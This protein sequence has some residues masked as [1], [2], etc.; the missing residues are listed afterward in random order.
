MLKQYQQSKKKGGADL[1]KRPGYY[2]YGVPQNTANM[3][4]VGSIYSIAAA[5]QMEFSEFVKNTIKELSKHKSYFNILMH[6]ELPLYFQDVDHLMNAI[7]TYILDKNITIPFTKFTHWNDLFIDIARIIYG[8]T[9][10]ILEDLSIITTGTSIKAS[11]FNEEINIIL[12]DKI[13]YVDDIIPE[14]QMDGERRSYILIVKRSQKTKSPFRE[15]VKTYYP[16]FIFIPQIFFKTNDI[17]QRIYTESDEIIK[18]IRNILKNSLAKDVRVTDQPLDL[19]V[20]VKFIKRT[21]HYK[22]HQ[23]FINHKNMCYAALLVKAKEYVYVPLHFSYYK[24]I[25]PMVFASPDNRQKAPVFNPF[26]R[27]AWKI[28]YSALESFIADFNKYV[29]DVSEAQGMIRFGIPTTASREDRIIPTYSLI[30]VDKFLMF[31]PF[32]GNISGHA[33]GILSDNRQFYFEDVNEKQ[34]DK[35]FAMFKKHM[36]EYD[37][38]IKEMR[39]EIF[40]FLYYDPDVIN[41]TIIAGSLQPEVP[42][43]L[44]SRNIN[45]ALYSKYLYQLFV[46]QFISYFDKETNTEIRKKLIQL[47]RKINF[48]KT[49]A[50]AK[51]QTEMRDFIPETSDRDVIMKIV[52][53]Y[54]YGKFDKDATIEDLEQNRYQFDRT[55][56][57]K[58]SRLNRELSR[59]EWDAIDPEKGTDVHKKIKKQIHALVGSVVQKII[60]P[61][62]P[63]NDDSAFEILISCLDSGKDAKK[64]CVNKKLVMPADKIKDYTDILVDDLLDPLKNIYLMSSI[65]VE[66]ILDNFRFHKTPGED[67]YI[68]F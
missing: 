25:D 64:Y 6:G 1:A 11:A 22:I 21:K 3:S 56:L 4:N 14:I 29:L 5:M 44:S 19:H 10:I 66:G 16:I 54:F 58:I 45:K 28:P 31:T 20:L 51:F 62:T 41:A 24:A 15:D 38:P 35:V 33:I 34:F 50:L 48:K 52:N 12:P 36:I 43:Q 40:K 61:G 7:Y 57:N 65:F 39:S 17:E 2:L 8:K 37:P 18:L 68:K 42:V 49:G 47:F 60:K 23:L 26:K 9:V 13:E 46:L 67:V 55:I 59:H 53:D 63:A 30:K 32:S 27:S